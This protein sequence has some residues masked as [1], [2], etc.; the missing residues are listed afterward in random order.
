MLPLVQEALLAELPP[1]WEQGETEDGTLYYFNSSTEE[2]IWEHP[3]DAH[4]RELVKVQKEQHAAI[5]TVSPLEAFDKVAVSE[6]KNVA[7]IA[8]HADIYSF[9]DISDEE[10]QTSTVATVSNK[11]HDVIAKP[12]QTNKDSGSTLSLKTL[13]TSTV[14]TGF[15]RDRSWLLDSDDDEAIIDIEATPTA[16]KALEQDA[17]GLQSVDASELTHVASSSRQSGPLRSSD[18][19]PSNAATNAM[20]QTTRSQFASI[21]PKSKSKWSEPPALNIE[22]PRVYDVPP[23]TASPSLSPSKAAMEQLEKKLMAATSALESE[24]DA[25]TETTRKLETAQQEARESNYRKMKVNEVKSKL[26]QQET[27][28]STREK[29]QLDKVTELERNALERERE[30]EKTIATLK[31]ENAQLVQQQDQTLSEQ[32]ESIQKEKMQTRAS[33]ARKDAEVEQLQQCLLEQKEDMAR[34]LANHETIQLELQQKINDY[35][36]A[37]EV[38]SREYTTEVATLREELAKLTQEHHTGNV[39]Q[40]FKCAQLEK[41]NGELIKEQE[42]KSDQLELLRRECLSLKSDQAAKAEEVERMQRLML[43]QKEW[44]HQMEEKTR[45]LQIDVV[46]LDQESVEVTRKNEALNQEVEEK[47]VEIATVATCFKKSQDELSRVQ[48]LLQKAYE[49]NQSI[50]AKADNYRHQVVLEQ[51]RV[52]AE[53]EAQ[54]QSRLEKLQTR[55]NGQVDEQNHVRFKL[56]SE[57][58]ELKAALLSVQTQEVKPLE[59]RRDQ[60]QHEVDQYMERVSVLEKEVSC[61]KKAM[62]QQTDRMSQLEGDLDVLGRREQQHKAQVE[63]LS[64]AK[65]TAEKQIAALQDELIVVQHDKRVDCDRLTFR[66]RDLESQVTQK[67]YEVKRLEEQ[68]TKAE[69]WRAKEAARVEKRDA[70]L[71]EVREQLT[72]LQTRQVEVANST[73]IRELRATK[74][75]IEVQNQQLKRDLREERDIRKR[76]DLRRT[77]EVQ[78]MQQAME[79]QLPQLAQACVARSSDEWAQKCRAVAK[80]LREDFH[81]SA[82]KERT[83]L[84][85]RERQAHEACEQVEQKLKM[86]SAENEF[87]RREIGRLEDNNKMLL[88]QL[89]T[90]RLYLTQRSMPSVSPPLSTMPLSVPPSASTSVNV[91]DMCRVNQLHAQLGILHA[92]FQQLFASNEQRQKSVSFS[93]T[94]RFEI[95]SSP[96]ASDA[97]AST[98]CKESATKEDQ[99]KW[100]QEEAAKRLA[101]DALM[102]QKLCT[103]YNATTPSA[104]QRQQEE[105]LTTLESLNAPQSQWLPFQSPGLGS[106]IHVN[107]ETKRTDPQTTLWYQQDYWRTKYQ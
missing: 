44:A 36:E 74:E 33:L 10:T 41:H 32:M 23:Q 71:L 80:K 7:L 97:R 90:I 79:W 11:S 27:A 8:S 91:S 67:E 49:D 69:T 20:N 3:L 98:R 2:S 53:A 46:R 24:R 18:D 76:D 61:T 16:S 106:L 95:S 12:A 94:D 14:A 52:R 31:A 56:Q 83:E 6:H 65:H 19:P 29:Q 57:V 37:A 40:A 48:T 88:E 63:A 25:H 22:R 73:E 105:L 86:A 60:L 70:Q 103:L 62:S 55:F 54:A 58:A 50:N 89:H 28:A 87:F 72:A 84:V 21:E 102:E 15:G 1:D 5:A 82:L 39:D 26:T 9:D 17:T 77:E 93:P 107:E 30:Q 38:T 35:S 100:K 47:R 45:L 85:A 13:P 81:L 42:I 64:T 68:F 92:Q 101:L 96:T 34:A 104:L 75:Q 78:R 43:Q 51:E 99:M 4:Y 66:V 59:Q